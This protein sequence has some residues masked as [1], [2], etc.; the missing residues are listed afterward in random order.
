[1]A[2]R[3]PTKVKGEKYV[4]AFPKGSNGRDANFWRQ[5]LARSTGNSTKICQ[6]ACI[7]NDDFTH[8]CLHGDH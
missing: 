8:Q 5:Q 6:I 7:R 1:M 4:E 2:Q 3:E